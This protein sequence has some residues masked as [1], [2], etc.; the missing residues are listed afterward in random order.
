[1]SLEHVAEAI[2][3]THSSVSRWERGKMK[4]TTAD[5]QKLAV[6]YGVSATQLAGPPAAA[7]MIAVLDRTQAIAQEMDPET[8]E[9]WLS[10]GERLSQ[11]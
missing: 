3:K 8:L 2:G 9:Q 1:M 7:S 6:L 4:L 10:I 5:L 11:K